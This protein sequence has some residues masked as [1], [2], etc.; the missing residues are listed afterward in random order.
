[1]NAPAQLKG[2]DYI[3]LGVFFLAPEYIYTLAGWKASPSLKSGVSIDLV[4]TQ[5]SISLTRLH[6]QISLN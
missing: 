4:S 6:L 2:K 1:M 3:S 5:E